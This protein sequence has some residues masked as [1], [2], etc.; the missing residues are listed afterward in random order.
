MWVVCKICWTGCQ[1]CGRKCKCGWWANMI[2]S[3]NSM[4]DLGMPVDMIKTNI[5]DIYNLKRW[6]TPVEIYDYY[7][8]GI[9]LPEKKNRVSSGEVVSQSYV[10]TVANFKPTPNPSPKCCYVK[11]GEKKT[12]TVWSRCIYCNNV[13]MYAPEV[14]PSYWLEK[15][16]E[17]HLNEQPTESTVEENNEADLNSNWE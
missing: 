9:D 12:V 16:I 3:A 1:W 17:S 11:E 8:N 10:N 13:K 2:G 15:E 4:Y 14:C 5:V 6:H 7:V